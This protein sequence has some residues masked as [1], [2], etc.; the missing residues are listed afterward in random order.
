MEERQFIIVITVIIYESFTKGWNIQKASV[1]DEAR[2]RTVNYNE[3]SLRTKTIGTFRTTEEPAI[4][5]PHLI[6]I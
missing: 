5:V 2:S 4:M 6:G 1:A 3:L